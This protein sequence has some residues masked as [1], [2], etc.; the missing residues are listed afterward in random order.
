MGIL[1]V[2]NNWDNKLTEVMEWV[3]PQLVQARNVRGNDQWSD[4]RYRNVTEFNM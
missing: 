3:G 2:K 4:I 1:Q